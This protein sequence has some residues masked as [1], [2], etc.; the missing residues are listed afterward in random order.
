[1]ER[2]AYDAGRAETCSCYSMSMS[3]T[4]RLQVLIES[5]QR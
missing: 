2:S 3:K 5:E 1:V 4:E